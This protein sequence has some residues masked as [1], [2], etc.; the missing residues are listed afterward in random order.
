MGAVYLGRD[1]VRGNE[2]AIKVLLAGQTAGATQRQRFQREVQALRRL[3]H[4]GLVRIL[5]AGEEQGV[6]WFAMERVEGESPRS[7]CWPLCSRTGR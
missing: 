3:D 1:P 4:P 2:V 7:L 6:P 5:E